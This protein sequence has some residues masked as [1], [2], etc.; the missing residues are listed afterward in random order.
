M[1]LYKELIGEKELFLG[2]KCVFFPAGGG[3]LEGVKGVVAFSSEK[4][5][6]SFRSGI[7]TVEGSALE[8]CKLLDGDVFFSGEIRQVSYQKKGGSARD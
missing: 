1:R 2:E 5:V 7:L 4:A 8:I 6:F 3:Y